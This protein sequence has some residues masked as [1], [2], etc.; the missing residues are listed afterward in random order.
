MAHPNQLLFGR[1]VVLLDK[2][3][4]RIELSSDRSCI[5]LRCQQDQLAS[6]ESTHKALRVQGLGVAANSVDIKQH[7]FAREL[8]ILSRYIIDI[9]AG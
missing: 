8:L 1:T 5:L 4:K 2:G 3:S 7:S 9:E 6:A